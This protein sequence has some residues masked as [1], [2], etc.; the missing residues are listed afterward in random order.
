MD[1]L[2]RTAAGSTIKDICN[3]NVLTDT[4]GL[5]RVESVAGGTGALERAHE[6][7][8][9]ARHSAHATYL[10]QQSLTRSSAQ[11]LHLNQ[12]LSINQPCTLY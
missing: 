9:S 5:V 4:F 2:S 10:I 6:V 11:V 1:L 7:L 3:A 8:T 12:L